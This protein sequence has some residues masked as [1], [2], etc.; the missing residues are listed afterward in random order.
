MADNLDT[1]PII[2]DL[3]SPIT[4]RTIRDA[5]RSIG[6]YTTPDVGRI[7]SIRI[8]GTAGAGL[9]TIVLHSHSASGPEIFKLIVPAASEHDGTVTELDVDFRG[10][11]MDAVAVAWVSGARMYIYLE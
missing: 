8:N 11:Y 10:I 4:A 9:G 5:V 6:D 1:N 7:K 3:N 2:I